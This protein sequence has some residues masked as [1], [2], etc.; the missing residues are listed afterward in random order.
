MG[1]CGELCNFVAKFEIA[2]KGYMRFVGTIEAKVDNKGRVFL[3]AVLR[4]AIPSTEDGTN[5]IMR[6]DLFEDCL[7]LYTE[8]T[9]Q[10][11]LDEL[12]SRLSVWNRHDQA[13]KR[14]F[15]ADAEWL[16]LDSNGRIL[17]PKRYLS[18]AEI[19]S[20]VTFIGMDDS[21]EIWAP[22]K[23]HQHQDSD[24]FA[25]EIEKIMSHE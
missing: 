12:K 19:T 15:S 5:L 8:E 1:N 22:H 6:K 3:P 9:W 7:V 2:L 14:R 13:L 16:T 23:L 25:T 10:A 20:E 17:L 11:R 4:R 18:M 21:I 24:D